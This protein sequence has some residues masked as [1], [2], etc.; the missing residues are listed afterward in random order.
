MKKPPPTIDAALGE[1]L[2][3]ALTHVRRAGPDREDPWQFIAFAM[4]RARE[5]HG[6]LFQD[7]WALWVSGEKRDGFFVEVGAADGVFL[8]NTFYLETLGWTGIV[9]EPN[10]RFA[11][12][13]KRRRCAVSH[14]C[15]SSTSGETVPFLAAEMGE[16]SR[17]ATVAF[18]DKHEA[19][20]QQGAQQLQV[21]TIT[22]NDLLEQHSAPRTI[23]YLSVDTEG[24]ELDILSAFD[25]DRWD[26]RAITV[27]HNHTPAREALYE[28]LTAKGFRRQFR[29]LSRFDDWYVKTA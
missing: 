27:E 10:P 29:E 15:V 8:S 24:A 6:Q 7:L 17:M 19:R 28:L 1:G 16:L 14:L 4:A 3:R 11:E 18:T 26:V 25:F 21:R 20:R 9:A 13:L 2:Q 12:K 5:A 22:L 23:D